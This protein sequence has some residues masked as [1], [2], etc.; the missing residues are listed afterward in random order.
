MRSDEEFIAYVWEKYRLKQKKSEGK[1]SEIV[2]AG[3]AEYQYHQANKTPHRRWMG[4][5]AAAGVVVLAAAV[6]GG[7]LFGP[8]IWTM[9][10][11]GENS[12]TPSFAD[13]SAEAAWDG[14]EKGYGMWYRRVLCGDYRP[15]G[16]CRATVIAGPEELTAHLQ[17]VDDQVERAG[18]EISSDCHS[19]WSVQEDLSLLLSRSPWHG[20]TKDIF[21]QAFFQE[22]DLL[23]IEYSSAWVFPFYPTYTLSWNREEGRLLIDAQQKLQTEQTAYYQ[24]FVLLPKGTMTTPEKFSVELGGESGI[25]VR[26]VSTGFLRMRRVLQPDGAEETEPLLLSHRALEKLLDE[27][28]QQPSGLLDLDA[29]EKIENWKE[30]YSEE[31]FEDCD[32]MVYSLTESSSSV[33]HRVFTTNPARLVIERWIEP[34]GKDEKGNNLYASLGDITSYLFFVEAPKG[35][36]TSA[37]EIQIEVRPCFEG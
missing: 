18:W 27:W 6:I 15:E 13:S 26:K 29:E 21:N 1:A 22:Q 24:L 7:A 32:L 12:G 30:R 33:Q 2:K 8:R 31:F 37:E 9:T 23:V 16:D 19:G 3:T 20:K 35:M 4:W 11:P 34:I 10:K 5:S 25:L 17:A 14:E 36:L 28:R